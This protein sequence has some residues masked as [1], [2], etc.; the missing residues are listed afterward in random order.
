M[1][2]VACRRL[3]RQPDREHAAL[4]ALIAN[5]DVPSMGFDRLPGDA[6]AEPDTSRR[7]T[8]HERPE[9][10]L[11]VLIPEPAAL[12]LDFDQGPVVALP[13]RHVNVP[14]RACELDRVL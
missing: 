3:F 2:P 11:R 13:R 8:T 10:L 7:M 6:K 9:Q 1:L 14:V 5:R 4:R 12:I